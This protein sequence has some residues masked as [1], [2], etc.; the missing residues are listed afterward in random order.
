MNKRLWKE[1]AMDFLVLALAAVAAIAV[2]VIFT[3]GSQA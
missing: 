2:G 3:Y 1:R